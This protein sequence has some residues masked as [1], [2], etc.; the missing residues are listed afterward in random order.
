MQHPHMYETCA[1]FV[2]AYSN[3]SLQEQSI[4]MT[5]CQ[6]DIAYDAP[7]W[8]TGEHMTGKTVA[9]KIYFH[10]YFFQARQNKVIVFCFVFH[11]VEV[12]ILDECICNTR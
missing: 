4:A 10:I 7:E 11:L 6:S 12:E 1:N 9:L 3:E 8:L 2:S 5:L